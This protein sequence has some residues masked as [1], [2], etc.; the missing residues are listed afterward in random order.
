MS[1]SLALSISE[2]RRTAALAPIAHDISAKL[3]F[4]ASIIICVI[5]QE[6]CFKC[7]SR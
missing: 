7:F 4:M 2:P 6:R 5:E 1:L 3:S